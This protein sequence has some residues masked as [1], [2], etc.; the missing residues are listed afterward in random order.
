MAD[1]WPIIYVDTWSVKI[2]F[3]IFE[4]CYKNTDYNF[5]RNW[6]EYIGIQL[7]NHVWQIAIPLLGCLMYLLHHIS[8]WPQKQRYG[9]RKMTGTAV[10]VYAGVSEQ[11]SMAPV[12][13]RITN[14]SS[15]FNC[16]IPRHCM[17][18]WQQNSWTKS[19]GRGSFCI[20]KVQNHI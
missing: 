1:N 11:N 3:R 16:S 20:A 13:G 18:R 5:L 7:Y 2:L 10:S 9:A 19:F 8:K 14:K 6:L 15:I 4:Y 12:T 17:I